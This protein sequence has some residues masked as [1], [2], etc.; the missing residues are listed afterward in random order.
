MPTAPL[1]PASYLQRSACALAVFC[2]LAGVVPAAAPAQSLPSAEIWVGSE[3]ERYLRVLQT[4]GEA[5]LQPWGV[6]GFSPGEVDALLPR[7]E[8][9]WSSRYVTPTS[10]PGASLAAVPVDAALRYNTGFPYGYNDAAVWAGRGLTAQAAGGAALRA[11]PLSVRVAPAVFWAHNRDFEMMPTGRPGPG[12]YANPYDPLRIDQPQRFGDRP[13]S[14]LDAGQ[15]HVRFDLLGVAAGLSTENQGWGP[16]LH[17]PIILGNNAPG[18]VH[19]FAGTASPLNVGIGRLQ[20]RVIWGRLEQS[21]YSP[22]LEGYEA[23]YATGAAASF[24]PRPLPGL[25]LGVTRFFHLPWP[26]EGLRPRDLGKLFETFARSTL[27]EDDPEYEGSL[28][29]QLASVFFRWVLPTA[30]MEVYGEYG[31][32]DHNWDA[33]D[34]LLEPDHQAGFLVGGQK[35]WRRGDGGLLVVRGELLNTMRPHLIRGR[36]Q[37][38]F[39]HHLLRQGHTHRGQVLGAAFGRGGGGGIVGVDVYGPGGRW[40]LEWV[41]GRVADDWTYWLDGESHEGRTDLVHAL[42][43]DGVLFRGRADVT[44]GAAAVYNLNRHFAGDAFNL[45]GRVGIRLRP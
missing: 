20:G 4:V 23:R 15:S 44:W 7:G 8:H 9:P 37:A 29:N 40:S 5:P 42:S 28:D 43:A 18:F 12:E 38:S 14:R 16:A 26:Q 35:S 11:G 33:L 3:L 24:S 34:F 21:E 1:P 22:A 13:Y 30:G 10:R 6:R 17:Q 2:L 19:G 39:Y 41:R 31:R 36:R 27:E 25:E 45:N 32:E